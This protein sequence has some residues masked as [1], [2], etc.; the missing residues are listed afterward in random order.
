MYL[1]NYMHKYISVEF[2]SYANIYN[3]SACIHEYSYE[4]DSTF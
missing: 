2:A 4:Q 3:A 1:L